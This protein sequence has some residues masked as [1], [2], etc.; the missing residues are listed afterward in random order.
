MGDMIRLYCSILEE[1]RYK[2]LVRSVF[3]YILESFSIYLSHEICSGEGQEK[4]L[5]T[6]F[7]RTS[8]GVRQENRVIGLTE[9]FRPDLQSRVRVR[10]HKSLKNQFR[11]ELSRRR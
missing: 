7:P 5:Q 10:G 11:F 1:N 9:T 6:T 3:S 4:S 8:H 2:C